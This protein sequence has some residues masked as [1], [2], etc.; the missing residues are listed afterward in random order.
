MPRPP[1]TAEEADAL[2]MIDVRADAS[3]AAAASSG[4]DELNAA[5]VSAVSALPL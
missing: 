3:A 5:A 4:S 1:S 2:S